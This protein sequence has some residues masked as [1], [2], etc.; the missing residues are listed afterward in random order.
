MERWEVIDA[1]Q[2]MQ[3]YIKEHI[4]D[5]INMEELARNSGY[6]KR[7]AIRLFKNILGKSPAEYIRALRLTDSAKNLLFGQKQI[8]EI[9]FDSQ[10]ETHEGFT[11]AFSHEFG[12][13]PK[14]YKAEK[15]PVK[16][17]V[18]Y[19]IKHYYTYLINKENG[20]M[21]EAKSAILCTVTIVKKPKRKLIIMRSKKALDYFSFCEE[22]G[23]DWEGLFNSIECRLDN[24]A[25][26]D[27]PDKLVTSGT[28]KCGAGVEIPF[29]YSGI[30]P[31]S[32][33]CI[34]LEENHA[35][36]FQ[37]EPFENEDD[38]GIAISTVFKAVENYNP[39]QYGYE[40]AL[41]SAPKYNYGAYCKMGAKVEV[42]VAKI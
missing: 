39:I 10:F 16:Y 38:Y 4:D 2:K 21:D 37:S 30:I 19:P 28:T 20:C 33:D 29:D 36:I 32:C 31:D 23:C 15:P 1:V 7:H 27:L 34:E 18:A 26:V 8:I 5:S 42:P 13:T 41:D 14:R 22:K 9:A 35:M 24:A 6:S 12:I 11:R 40:F 25:I 17:F 3:D